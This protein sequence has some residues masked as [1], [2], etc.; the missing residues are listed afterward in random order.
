MGASPQTKAEYREEIARKQADVEHFKA[1]LA[2][3]TDKYNR[4]QLRRTIANIKGEIAKLKA[5]MANAP[6]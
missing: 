5:E 2:S 4:N 6:K 1:M 3:S